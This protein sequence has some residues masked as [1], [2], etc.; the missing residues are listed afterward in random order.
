MCGT[1]SMK[2]CI[3]NGINVRRSFNASRGNDGLF[4]QVFLE[5]ML[6]EWKQNQYVFPGLHIDHVFTLDKPWTYILEINLN[7]GLAI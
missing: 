1:Q 5:S 6:M 2:L 4:I 7:V 3:E